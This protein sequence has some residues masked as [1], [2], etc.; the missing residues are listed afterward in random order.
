MTSNYPI[1]FDTDTNLFLVQ[2]GLRLTLSEDYNPGDTSILVEGDVFTIASVPPTGIITLTDQCSD[3]K[4]RAISF[5][6]SG[7]DSTSNIFSGLE[8]LSGFEDNIKYKRITDVTISVMAE[9]HNC[10]KDALINIQEFCG[11]EGVTDTM[12][13]GDTLEGRV[14]FLRNLVL[15]PKA[16]FTSDK[17]FGNIPLEVEFED[18]S[19]RLGT[20]GNSGVISLVWDFGDHT[21]SSISYSEISATDEVPGGA[22]DVV[23]RD[24]DGGKIKKTYYQPGI[25]DVKLTVSNNF[26]SDICEF[27]AYINARQKAPQ[28]A[29][30][31]FIQYTYQSVTP[32]APPN[33]PYQIVPR[34]KSPINTII[35]IEI[36][37]GTFI[38]DG[39]TYSKSGELLNDLGSPIDPIV[40]YT[41]SLGDDL[42]HVSDS[43][44]K[45]AYSV[46]GIYD[47]KLRVDTDSGAYRITT[48]ENAIDIIENQN[49]WFWTIT[50]NQ[51][52]SYEYGLLSETFKLASSNTLVVQRNSS[53]L[54]GEPEYLKQKH[55]FE[56]NTGFA[57]RST[58]SSGK[59]G[60][61]L[62][63]YASGRT[64]VEPPSAE[65][66][67]V[68]EYNAFTDI[69]IARNSITRPWNWVNFNSSNYSY[70]VFGAINGEREPDQ[71]LTNV[72]K[73]K[74]DIGSYTCDE[75]DLTAENYL[76]GAD[77]LNSNVAV[78]DSE[79]NSSYGHFSVYRSTWKNNVGYLLRNDSVGSFFRLRSFY[80]TEG[81][82]SDPFLN[83]R[84]LQDMQGI[85]R[86]E[87]QLVSLSTGV[88]FLNNTGSVARYEPIT[89]VWA[90]G[91]PGVNSLAYRSLQDSTVAGF[92]EES[93]PLLASSDG[94]RR[95]Y[96]SFDY[97]SNV[98][99]KF[100]EIDLTFSS[101]GSRP[102]GEQWLMTIY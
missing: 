76:N 62:I 31:N 7:F 93:N 5:Y 39:S 56:R 44:A 1:S 64:A 61:S 17:R 69:Y 55:E 91:G 97:S 67:Y 58:V 92:D 70:F 40:T 34:I 51:A 78:Y 72:K 4:L 79:G 33:G 45:A 23:I 98:F 12:P 88:F 35:N 87:G 28:E 99:I 86:T 20:D 29:V 50:N 2:N 83:I 63:Y 60:S 18:L 6:Y 27:P 57:P 46:G 21:Y 101:I 53:F 49:L 68:T 36:P 73:Q 75:V 94:D 95:A 74:Y 42:T 81:T 71:S 8:I 11:V 13:F 37:D 43:T 90:A 26:G 22:I 38:Y 85:V 41:W 89:M 15:Q 80:R 19:F 30:I 96:L 25:Y 77:E 9:H 24:T 3:K 14:N 66:I 65:K 16:W 48:Y 47:L 32:G 82:L 84:K 59:G 100:N 10:I 102:T 52:R 54:Q